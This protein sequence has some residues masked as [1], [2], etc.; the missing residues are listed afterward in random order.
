MLAP[1][2]RHGYTVFAV[3]HIFQPEATVMQI[4]ED[5]NRAVR[6]IRFNAHHYGGTRSGLG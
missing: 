2:L 3:C 1:L 6:F 5:V 4:V